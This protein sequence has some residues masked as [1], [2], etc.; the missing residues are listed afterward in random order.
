MTQ[1]SMKSTEDVH[2]PRRVNLVD[3]TL[4]DG[5]QTPGVAFTLGQRLAILERLAEIGIDEVEAGIPA[6]GRE[7]QRSLRMMTS[8]GLPLRL[9]AWCRARAE[10]LDA[11]EEC[12]FSAVHFSVP[13]DPVL[14]RSLGWHPAELL[15]RIQAISE[16]A[17]R[18]FLY[19][20]LGFQGASRTPVV[21]LV[22]YARLSA[23]LGV[24]R[25]RL[26][27]SAG[28]W[29]PDSVS[30][31]VKAVGEALR[32]QCSLGV[33]MHNDLGLA[34]AN[35]L[36][37]LQ[38]G[39]DAIDVTVGGLG[40]RAGNAALEQLVM[41]VQAVPDLSCGVNSVMLHPLCRFVANAARQPISPSQP[42]CGERVF[43]H[44]S[45]IHVRAQ[46]SDPMSYQAFLPECVG[47][48]DGMHMVVGRH[49]GTFSI[50]S[51]LAMLGYDVTRD[52]AASLLAWVREYA[53]TS[54]NG[55]VSDHEL[56]ELLALMRGRDEDSGAPD[57]RITREVA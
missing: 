1:A 25:V 38:A 46:F 41:A 7:E 50:I 9:T 3:T 54:G 31:A 22:E 48:Q 4:R 24:D 33:H 26:A 43:M 2:S 10:D 30:G 11:A 12:G 49:S 55:S 8:L 51:S 53:V 15:G 23:E 42:V 21:S 17:R 39:A 52:E 14:I 40:E 37:A 18:R 5:E 28:C 56:L 19:V 6:M 34:T 29:L 27:D 44:E 16:D 32:G 13:S 57:K 36:I 45:G 47:N 20:S 35:S